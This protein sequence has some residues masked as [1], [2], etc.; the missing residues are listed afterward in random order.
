M[1]R[2]RDGPMVLKA[3]GPNHAHR[4]W[5]TGFPWLL[6]LACSSASGTPSGRDAGLDISHDLAPPDGPGAESN[7]DAAVTDGL[8]SDATLVDAGPDRTA[9]TTWT[10]CG[11]SNGPCLCD[12]LA[13]C[14]S[15]AGG[16]YSSLGSQQARVCA[17]DGDVCE[18][19]VFVETEG[20]G[21]AR[22]CRVPVDGQ[23]CTAAFGNTSNDRCVDL[24]TCNLLL[25]DCPPDVTP[26]GPVISCR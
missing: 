6:V 21:V 23:S 20:G 13:A 5:G 11:W 15:V 26:G 2:L 12:G 17:T 8:F 16:S 18:Y 3:R 4:I 22:R 7:I 9:F 25:G 19:V 10:S 1:A 24:F 14:A